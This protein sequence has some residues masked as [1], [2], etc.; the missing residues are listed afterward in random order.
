MESIINN[1]PKQKV[2]GPIDFTCE[3]YQTIN[4]K[5][6]A[7][8]QN[9]IQME[10]RVTHSN[11]IYEASIILITKSDEALN[12]KGKLKLDFKNISANGIQQ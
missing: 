4:E 3:F 1:L 11:S 12:M 7:Y 2:V 6:I 8:L 5:V 9:L 10:A